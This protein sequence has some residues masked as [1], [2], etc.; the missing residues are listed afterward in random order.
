MIGAIARDVIGSRFE[1]K[2]IWYLSH[3]YFKAE[4]YEQVKDERA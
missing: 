4:A 2:M 1:G 3:G